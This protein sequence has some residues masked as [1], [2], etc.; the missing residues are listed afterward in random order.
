MLS[1][2]GIVFQCLVDL[3]VQGVGA[4]VANSHVCLLD[5]G[6]LDLFFI[7]LQNVRYSS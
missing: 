3:W 1:T 2:D 5:P 6:G 4:E 7:F